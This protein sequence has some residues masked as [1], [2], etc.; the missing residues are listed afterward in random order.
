MLKRLTEKSKF[1]ILWSTCVLSVAGKCNSDRWE[2]KNKKIVAAKKDG[3][4]GLKASAGTEYCL[5]KCQTQERQYMQYCTDG[6]EDRGVGRK[7][8]IHRSM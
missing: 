5:V 8:E 1:R 3:N 6:L 2:K 4:R 7:K